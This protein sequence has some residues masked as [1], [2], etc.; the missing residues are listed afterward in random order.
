MDNDGHKQNN[1]FIYL[2]ISLTAYSQHVN[3]GIDVAGV[4]IA[5]NSIAATEI[6]SNTETGIH[7]SI[8]T[9]EDIRL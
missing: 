9:G 7:G 1:Q 6:V 3:V 2:L 4:G 5:G 8:T